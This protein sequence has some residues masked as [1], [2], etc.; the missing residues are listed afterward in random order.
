MLSWWAPALRPGM[1]L[2]SV[3]LVARCCY[4]GVSTSSDT[5]L[6]R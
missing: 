3:V 5:G 6:E 2:S 4:N 1:T